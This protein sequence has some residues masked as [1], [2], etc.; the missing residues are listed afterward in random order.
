MR[1]EITS[2]KNPRIRD[3][4]KLKEKKHRTLQRAFLIEG[5]R[6]VREARRQGAKISCYIV[7]AEETELLDLVGAGEPD[8][9]LVVPPEILLELSGTVTPQGIMA[10][11]E[12]PEPPKA[13][14]IWSGEGLWFYLDEIR[15][16]GNLGTI[17]RSAHA[18]SLDG[19]FLAKGSADPYQDKVLRSTMGSIFQVPLILEAGVDLLEKALA[20]GVSLYLTDLSDAGELKDI[21]LPPRTI[22]VIGNEARGV[23]EAIRALPHSNLYIPMPGGAESLNAAV[24]ASIIMYELRGRG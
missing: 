19:I 13:E 3:L 9:I 21:Q 10:A 6:F 7:S 8:D 23:Q 22:I 11:V 4:K 20:D 17:I 16:P 14:A 24:A 1:T 18:F 15:D 2:L 5:L 12:M